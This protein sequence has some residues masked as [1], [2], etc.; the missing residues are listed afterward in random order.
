MMRYQ[1]LHAESWSATKQSTLTRGIHLFLPRYVPQLC[2]LTLYIRKWRSTSN[3]SRE[4]DNAWWFQ[5]NW[6]M[7]EQMTFK[8]LQHQNR[9]SATWT[10]TNW[11]HCERPEKLNWNQ[12]TKSFISAW[13]NLW[14]ETKSPHPVRDRHNQVEPDLEF[15]RSNFKAA[16]NR[17]A[18]NCEALQKFAH[19]CT[20]LAH[21]RQK[22]CIRQNQ[23]GTNS[24]LQN[25]NHGTNIPLASWLEVIGATIP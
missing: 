5:Q 7:A 3:S 1:G 21:F 17:H 19:I 16:A 24:Y 10:S 8:S 25:V 20:N 12:K 9:V 15:T 6:H 14:R 23:F 4:Q 22:S 2:R 11:L 18:N 13:H